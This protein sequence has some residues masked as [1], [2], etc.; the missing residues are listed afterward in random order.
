MSQ[1]TQL[2]NASRASATRDL[3]ASLQRA[4]RTQCIRHTFSIVVTIALVVGLFVFS[5]CYGS[6]WYTP[7]EVLQ[8]IG[9]ETVPGASYAV[10]ELRLPRALL[11][12][13]AGLA[14]GIGGSTFQMLLRNPL[15][16]P[17]VI[18]VSSAA[19]AAGATAIVI[20]RFDSVTTSL[21]SIAVSL[22]VAAAI[23][24]IAFRGGFSSGRFILV[25]IGVA[26]ILHSVVTYVLSKANS[27][28]LGTVARWLSGSINDTTWQ[29]VV[30]TV[31]ACAILSPL[32]LFS[33]HQLRAL[34]LGDQLARGLG[35]PASLVQAGCI[36][37]AVSLVAVATAACGPIAFV[38]FMS[39]P[40]AVRLFGHAAPRMLTAG[41]VGALLV[42]GADLLGQHFLPARYPVGVITGA[43]GAPFLIAVLL[44]RQQKGAS[45]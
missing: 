31:I 12:L 35:V 3:A 16:S 1:S 28:D 23:F 43:L 27:W 11:G 45:A 21:F 5:L 44:R 9:G 40:L 39:G 19:A 22:V 14:L 38:A 30:P 29:V 24:A 25:G 2:P 18:G 15:A 8:V 42:L 17:D 6:T 41:L 37:L 10:G 20:F 33:E 36:L 4:R 7:A 32:L 26:A 34:M 13:V